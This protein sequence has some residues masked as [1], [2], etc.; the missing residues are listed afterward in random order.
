MS[1]SETQAQILLSLARKYPNLRLFRNNTGMGW[2]GQT[3]SQTPAQIVIKN[4]RPL[5]AGLVKGSSDLIGIKKTLIT[6][7]MVGKEIGVFVAIEVKS[8]SGRLTPEQAN[9]IEFV[10]K[11]GGIAGTANNVGQAD[12]IIG[13]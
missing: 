9:F 12:S 11:F 3:V 8:E 7:D 13:Q 6:P 10:G 2:Q 5:H 1:E 4:P